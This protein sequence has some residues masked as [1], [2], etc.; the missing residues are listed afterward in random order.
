MLCLPENDI[1]LIII[2]VDV[3]SGM[4]EV[5]GEDGAD[6]ILEA[7]EVVH[8]WTRKHLHQLTMKHCGPLS[9]LQRRTIANSNSMLEC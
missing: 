3:G 8:T 7:V 9:R 1:T 2:D 4:R 6:L 5:P